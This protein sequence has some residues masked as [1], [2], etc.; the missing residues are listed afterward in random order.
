[1]WDIIGGFVL[2]FHSCTIC[3][4]F[5]PTLKYGCD[6]TVILLW[7]FLSP[8]GPRAFGRHLGTLHAKGRATL[9][10]ELS[11]LM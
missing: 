4:F 7:D 10:L 1:M 5:I 3:K 9:V 8:M 2:L 11:F 6:V